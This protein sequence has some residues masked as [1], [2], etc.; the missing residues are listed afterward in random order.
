MPSIHTENIGEMAVIR[1]RRQNCTE[2]GRFECEGCSIPANL[3][4]IGWS[5]PNRCESSTSRML[6][7][8]M[9]LLV[10]VDRRFALAS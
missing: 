6:E 3:C 8:M 7:E 4:S 10:R 2:R 9:A 5:T 1:V